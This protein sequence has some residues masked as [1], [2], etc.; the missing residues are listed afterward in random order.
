MVA[1]TR[2][3]LTDVGRSQ[4]LVPP[5]MLLAA[6][7]TV[8]YSSPPSSLLAEYAFT[9]VVLYA[10]GAWVGLVTLNVEDDVQRDLTAVA[11]GAPTRGVAA[12]LL[13]AHL[14]VAA[15]ALV[16]TVTPVALGRATGPI[17]LDPVSGLAAH[18]I[19]GA[20]GTA[21]GAAFCRPAVRRPGWAALGVVAGLLVTVP[22]NRLVAL[23][24]VLEVTRV[25]LNAEGW[26]ALLGPAAAALAFSAAAGLLTA[27]L[28]ATRS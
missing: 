1:L 28:V 5:L 13:A 24:P 4:R 26:R 7:M 6:V 2:Y 9:T 20:S 27:R 22:L 10:L 16:L 3:V 11:A 15:V 21:L 17:G 19:C 12:K 8:L 14:V 18:L 25:L 23:P